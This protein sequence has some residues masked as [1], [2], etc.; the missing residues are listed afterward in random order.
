MAMSVDA[1]LPVIAM[2]TVEKANV[3]HV[4]GLILMIIVMIYFI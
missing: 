1:D 4:P 2:E 3:L